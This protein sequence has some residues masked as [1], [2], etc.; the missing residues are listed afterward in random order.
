MKPWMKWVLY[1]IAALIL[2]VAALYVFGLTRPESIEFS[3]QTDI[4]APPEKVFALVSNPLEIPKW[5][6]AVEKVEILSQKPLRYRMTMGG[7]VGE[8]EEVERESPMRLVTKTVGDS[9]GMDAEWDFSVTAAGS[10]TK[11]DEKV[12]MKF[13]S[14]W[15]RAA[16][17]IMDGAAEERKVIALMKAYAEKTQ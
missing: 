2:L 1:P 6:P 16:A 10:G 8:M 9:M 13:H 4:A 14:P 11:I 5:Y 7:T 17:A 12:K 3:L 15:M